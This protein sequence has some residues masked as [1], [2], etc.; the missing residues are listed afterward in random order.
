MAR[1][2]LPVS[3]SGLA[4]LLKAS[5]RAAP[6]WVPLVSE[7]W[8]AGGEPWG[9]GM[10]RPPAQGRSTVVKGPGSPQA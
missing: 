5:V 7:Q 1:A 3:P 9:H 10:E 2:R 6:S 4:A 8:V